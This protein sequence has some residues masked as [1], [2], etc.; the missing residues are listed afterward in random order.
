MAE[1]ITVITVPI[2]AVF[3]KPI[4]RYNRPACDALMGQPMV[5]AANASPARRGEVLRDPS[6]NVGT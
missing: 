6:R 1:P 2:M 5:N 4:R 3:L